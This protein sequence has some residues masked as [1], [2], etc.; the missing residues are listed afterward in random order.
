MRKGGVGLVSYLFRSIDRAPE[1]VLIYRAEHTGIQSV[2]F[3][4]GG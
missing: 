2:G 4:K 1:I 3:S